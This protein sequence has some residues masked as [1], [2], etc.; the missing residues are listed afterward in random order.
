MPSISVYTEIVVGPAY[1][2][3]ASPNVWTVP[4]NVPRRALNRETWPGKRTS[5]SFSAMSVKIAWPPAATN[6]RN[7]SA[8]ASPGYAPF[9]PSQSSTTRAYRKRIDGSA[10]TS[11]VFRMSYGI[12]S[13][14]RSTCVRPQSNPPFRI[15]T[16]VTF[17][18]G[19][20]WSST[21][22]S[23]SRRYVTV[24]YC[25]AASRNSVRYEPQTR[26]GPPSNA[27]GG[28]NGSTFNGTAGG[29]RMRYTGTP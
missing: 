19:R 1:W 9:H 22:S 8:T 27:D 29:L 28:P 23:A 2:E 18:I 5:M 10:A 3:G 4:L 13:W 11:V 25:A 24:G 6:V 15:S 26:N 17:R 16:L 21:W 20:T 12:P 7:A 14:S